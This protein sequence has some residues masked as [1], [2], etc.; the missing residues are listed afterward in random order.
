MLS[1]LP[2]VWCFR[3]RP[4]QAIRGSLASGFYPQGCC[5]NELDIQVK[6][7]KQASIKNFR[8][9]AVIVIAIEKM[10][11]VPNI[12]LFTDDD[13]MDIINTILGTVWNA[14]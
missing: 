4:I 11:K 8:K 1:L 9:A 3:E 6:V 5:A 14:E 13:L 2:T 7:T 10:K 12:S